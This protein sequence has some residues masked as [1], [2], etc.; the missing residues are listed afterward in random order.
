MIANIKP[1]PGFPGYLVSNCGR[2]VHMPRTARSPIRQLKPQPNNH[3][4][5]FVRINNA[6][7]VKK[8]LYVHVLVMA[9]FGPPRPMVHYYRNEEGGFVRYVIRHLDGKHSNN[10][11]DNLKWGT[12]AENMADKVAHGRQAA[13]K[14]HGA[15]IKRGRKRAAERRKYKAQGYVGYIPAPEKE[16]DKVHVR[17]NDIEPRRP[18]IDA[19]MNTKEF[20][21]CVAKAGKAIKKQMD[22][23]NTTAFVIPNP[24]GR[25]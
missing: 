6:L 1:I 20:A 3:G 5:L 25:K 19:M 13:G 18:F 14:K 2:V 21:D 16:S 22:R 10:R 15:A 7:G 17:L 9:A 8:K 12:D 24:G 23:I 11:S 4:H